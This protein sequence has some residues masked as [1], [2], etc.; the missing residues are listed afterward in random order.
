MKKWLAIPA[1]ILFVLLLPVLL[2]YGFI[3]NALFRRRLKRAAERSKC[4][5]CGSNLGD[6]A[7]KLAD[8]HWR[9]YVSCLHR[10]HPGVRFRLVRLVHAI[11][12]SCGASLRFVEETQLFETT[13]PIP[14]SVEDSHEP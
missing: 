14:P 7:L 3:S 12:V 1:V 9:E 6:E 11:C 10:Q 2:P 8:E 13:K 5:T 4:P